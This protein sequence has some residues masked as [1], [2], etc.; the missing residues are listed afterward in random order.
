MSG[1][2]GP[3]LARHAPVLPADCTN[4]SSRSAISCRPCSASASAG[5]A[6]RSGLS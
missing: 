2:P 4:W 6:I 3:G 1:A 5:P